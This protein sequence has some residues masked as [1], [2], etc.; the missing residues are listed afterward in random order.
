[1]SSKNETIDQNP[2]SFI[3]AARRAQIIECAIDAIATLGF[4]HASL[5]Q[6]AKRAEIS[7]SVISYYFAGKEELLQAVV[8]HV[9]AAADA[10][11]R[12]RVELGSGAR[13]ELRSFMM[14]YAGFINAGPK[15]LLAIQNIVLGGRGDLWSPGSVSRTGEQ[16]AVLRI[17]QWGQDDRVFR[18]FDVRVMADALIW[19]LRSLIERLARE[20]ALDVAAA[21][22]ELFELFDRATRSDPV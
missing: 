7:T 20:P 1:M 11:I 5:A 14:A 13:A 12:P 2:A 16:G 17:L 4:A 8:A 19:A 22:A 6:I 9:A 15:S 10:F 18:P 3:E 21:G